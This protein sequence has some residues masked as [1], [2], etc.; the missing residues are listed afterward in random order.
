MIRRA[1]TV[2]SI[3]FFVV[4]FKLSVQG[5]ATDF[6]EL[7]MEQL[8]NIT[9]TGA[10]RFD[11]KVSEAPASVNIVTKDD[12]KKY[13]YRTLTDILTSLPGFYSSYD[14]TYSYLGVRGF[15]LP[16]DY[17]TRFLILLDGHRL[18][19]NTFDQSGIGTDFILDTDLIDRVEAIKG[20]GSSLYG[21]N[22]F[23]S[24]I[25][26][27]TRKGED[28]NGVEVSGSA[29]SFDTYTER[30]SY[31]KGF[32]NGFEM[33]L[34]ASDYHSKGD[35]LYFKEF[36]DPTTNNGVTGDTDYDR[37][38]TAF[39]RLSY[40]DFTFTG[41]YN[42]RTKGIP[43]AS[44]GTDFNTRANHVTDERAYLDLGYTHTFDN[45][46]ITKG[47]VFFDQYSYDGKYSY[48]PD[49][50]IDKARGTWWGGDLLFIKT[51]WEK[52]KVSIG[53]EYVTNTRQDQSNYYINPYSS[54]LDEKH[55][56]TRWAFFLQ[57]EYTIRKN[58]TLN[59]GARYDCYSTF[60]ETINP[61]AALIYNPFQKTTLKL[62]YGSA[63]R[64]PNPYELYYNDW[65]IT[66]ANPSLGPEKIKTYEVV[67]ERF[68]LDHFRAS[69]GVFYNTVS[70]LIVQEVDADGFSVFQNRGNVD[71]KGLELEL[72][73]IW[74]NGLRGHISYTYQ[75]AKD[76]DTD[77]S[78]VNSPMH[79]AKLNVI[80]PLWRDKVFSGIEMQYTS[81]R[82]TLDR[83][84]TGSSFITNL[85]LYTQKLIKGLE[86]SFSVYNLFDKKYSYPA[87]NEHP[88]NTIEQDGRT[89]RVNFAYAF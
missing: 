8:M 69:G 17:N 31:G 37:N 86:A 49:I 42:T 21:S 20:P 73:S 7:S 36:D 54:V 57:D 16:G 3:V 83:T 61:R 4:L 11:Q 72:E 15:G 63:F 29:G 81:D 35:S 55:D 88:M 74:Q 75:A 84:R 68:F 71:T 23:F 14:R 50:N 26:V 47:H 77:R 78:L 27:I 60:G 34:S 66:K 80:V 58:L 70:N 82:K 24:V 43:T 45:V 64:A 65:I 32:G 53:G 89:W 12:I 48:M 30:L 38:K 52:H 19:D 9:V 85:T 87:A 25:N 44:F 6:T 46:A 22:A 39:A 13:G 76:K 5:Q 56:S 1:A 41:A 62:L 67:L 51:L 18:N 28:V 2:I 79:M 59:V 33:L 40:R 10:S